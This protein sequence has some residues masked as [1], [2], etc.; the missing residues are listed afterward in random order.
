MYIIRTIT[1]NPTSLSEQH[2][3]LQLYQTQD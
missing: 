1:T 2:N 3:S